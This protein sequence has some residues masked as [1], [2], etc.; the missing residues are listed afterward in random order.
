MIAGAKITDTMES[1][2]NNATMIKIASATG[3]T[4]LRVVVPDTPCRTP[5]THAGG[6]GLP[7]VSA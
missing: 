1:T 4:L 7:I 5:A 3:D 2:R 6:V